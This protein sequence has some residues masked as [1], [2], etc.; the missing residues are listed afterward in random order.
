MKDKLYTFRSNFIFE[1]SKILSYYRWYLL[2]FFIVFLISFI[3]GASTCTHYIDSITYE[4]LINKY[5]LEFL[6]KDKGFWGYVFILSAWFV[7]ICLVVMLFTKNKIFVVIDILILSLCS[8]IFGF[9]VTVV[10]LS[11]GLTGIIFGVLVQFICG[12]LLLFLLM[13]LLAYVVKRLFVFRGNC[14]TIDNQWWRV[15]SLIIIAG[16]I[17]I[18]INT[19]LLS[20]IHIFVIVD[21]FVR[22]FW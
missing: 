7:G 16:I 19:V 20:G 11:F 6:S 5:L 3:T 10:I 17:V 13:F 21:W 14:I 15:L 12:L 4:N 8:Y 2:V 22:L 18:I 1:A 9:D